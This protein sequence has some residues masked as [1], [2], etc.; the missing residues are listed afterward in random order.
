MNRAGLIVVAAALIVAVVTAW[1]PVE[2]QEE[3]TGSMTLDRS[4]VVDPHGG[5]SSFV[6]VYGF[7]R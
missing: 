3:H 7:N 2:A 5:T 4:V 6:P 1:Q